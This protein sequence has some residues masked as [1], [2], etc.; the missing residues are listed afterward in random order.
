MDPDL[1]DPPVEIPRFLEEIEKGYDL[2]W[3]IRK[4]KK[5][6]C[7]NR[8]LYWFVQYILLLVC[9]N[10]FTVSILFGPSSL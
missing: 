10:F 8:L 1:Q 2:V 9:N 6:S 4:E 7:I 5:D 3:G